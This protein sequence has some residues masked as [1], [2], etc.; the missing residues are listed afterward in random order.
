MNANG[1]YHP[2]RVTLEGFEI[3]G[4]TIPWDDID[5]AR[6]V[7][8]AG[9]PRVEVAPLVSQGDLQDIVKKL[10][11]GAHN[12]SEWEIEFIKDMLDHSSFSPK[13]TEVILKIEQKYL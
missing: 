2:V 12:M 1:H 11:A 9:V 6:S 5:Q 8:G 7:I 4:D 13:Q 3:A 10:D